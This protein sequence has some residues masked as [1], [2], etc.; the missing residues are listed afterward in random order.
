MEE[1]PQQNDDVNAGSF[2]IYAGL[3]RPLRVLLASLNS[4]WPAAML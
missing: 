4:L 1:L 2:A 3:S